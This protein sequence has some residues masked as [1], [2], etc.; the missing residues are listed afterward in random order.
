[1]AGFTL[2]GW[3]VK[4]TQNQILMETKMIHMSPEMK[5]I[6]KRRMVGELTRLSVDF[7]EKSD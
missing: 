7:D 5:A 6:T 2:F 1:M 4:A 3:A